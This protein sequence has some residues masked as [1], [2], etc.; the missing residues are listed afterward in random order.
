LALVGLGGGIV[1]WGVVLLLVF[2]FDY[3][4]IIYIYFYG[5]YW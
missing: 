1:V 3:C 4:L 2:L 5:L